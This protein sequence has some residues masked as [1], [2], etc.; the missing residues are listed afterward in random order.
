MANGN[1]SMLHPADGYVLTAELRTPRHSATYAPALHVAYERA[2]KAIV[3][4]V[5][6]ACRTES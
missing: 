6:E 2:L 1:G 5:E 4:N 3:N